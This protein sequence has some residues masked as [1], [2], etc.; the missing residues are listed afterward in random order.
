MY[1]FKDRRGKILYV[2][3]ARSL[4]KRVS[5]YFTKGP[6]ASK[7]EALLGSWD[8]LETIVTNT[9][10]EALLL[11]NSLIKKHK[12][13][14]NICLRDDKTYPYVKITTGEE[15]PRALVT[16]RVQEDGHSYFGPFWGGLARRIMRMITRHF[17]IRTCTIE[18][19]GTL[20]RPCL[21]YDLHACLGPCVAG[22]TTKAA[23]DD[24]VR[25]VVLFLQGRNRELAASLERKMREA[26]R[27]ENFE[28]AAAYR[29]ALR[30]VEDVSEHQV[31]HSLKGE[32]VDV[33]GLFESGGDVAVGVLVVRGGVIQDR[34][35]F[36]FEKSE[37]V[38][39]SAFLDAFLPQFYDANPFLP[40]EVHLPVAIPDPG[41]LEAFLAARRGGRVAVRV[42]QR[43]PARERVELAQ[44]NARERHKVRFRRL[45]GEEA[46]GVERLARVL[47]LSVP[48]RRIEAFDISHLQGTDS[49]ASLVV[50]EDGKPK[51]ADYRLFGIASQQLL[52]PDDFKSMAEAVERRYRKLRDEGLEM[53]DL[54]LVDGGRGQLQ[55]AL[56]ALDRLGVEL[57]VVGLAKREEE[58]WIPERPDPVRLSRK[59]PALQLIQR[60][61]DEAHR[62]AI[63]RHRG[64]RS[65]RMRETSLREIP[66]IGPTRAR[67]LLTRFGSISGIAAAAPGEI[68]E[69]VGAATARA[70]R[71]Y[72]E[73]GRAPEETVEIPTGP[74]EGGH[75]RSA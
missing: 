53:P 67:T 47:D 49:I 52:A 71:E 21:Y 11:E 9:E 51:K 20:P 68:E 41:L 25:D 73:A 5:S 18:I 23:Y 13:R 59:D 26:S 65:K 55:A 32:S 74:G 33:F 37:E 50:F 64:R 34:R 31:V 19:D 12:P 29:D 1:L 62:F 42:P 16:R 24:A 38:D 43:G 4:R 22:L 35:E 15:W 72:L 70:V 45:G 10:L 75:A 14:Y 66:G 7:T 46:L 54:V 60:V 17:Q 36:F 58:I 3:K 69:A 28:M 40:V 27:E 2:G 63:T 57:P 61:R 6:E 48:P 8:D 44:D 39:P 30:T 56:T